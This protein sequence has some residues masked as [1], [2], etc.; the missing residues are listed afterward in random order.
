M[1]Q[2]RT[3]LLILGLSL[4]GLSQLFISGCATNPVTGQPDFVLM[5]EQQEIAIGRQNHQAILKEIGQYP[6]PQLADYV[7]SVGERLAVHSHRPELTYRFTVLDSQQV[8]AF[9]L[10]GGYIYIY[11]GLLAYLNSE[12][13]LA[14]VLG[15]ELGHVTARHAVRQQSAAAATGIIGSV[16]AGASGVRGAGDIANIA[17]TALI[18]GY[19]REHELEA[20]RLGAEYLAR[21]G[22]DPKAMI[23][24]IRVLK[25]QE[26]FERELARKEGREP[27]IYHGVFATHPD[28]DRRLQEVVNAAQSLKANGHRTAHKVFLDAL[29]GLVFGDSKKDGIRRGNHFYHA[30]MNLALTFPAGWV[31]ENHADRVTARTPDKDGEIQFTLTDINKKISPREFIRQRLDIQQLNHGESI[32]LGNLVGYTGLSDIDTKQG[33]ALLRIAVLYRRDKALVFA[34]I[35]KKDAKPYRYDRLYLDTV[36]SFHALGERER[37]LAEP[38][39]IDII[40]AT[41]ATR[42]AGLARESAISNHAEAQLRLLND[43]YPDGEPTPGQWLKIVE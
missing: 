36:K 31:L 35:T 22:Y 34:G 9:A 18:R 12:A 40:R 11:R 8:N 2:T 4:L 29:D 13:E 38:L 33:P 42:F 26:S 39:R 27:N 37:R 20:D 24:V 19:G 28:N 23:N 30:D 10:P 16:I 15:H 7:Q 25:N 3:K 43:L 41:P 6:D 5:S 17:G 1:T 21:S 32:K 14:A